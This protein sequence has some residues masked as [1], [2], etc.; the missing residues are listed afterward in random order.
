MGEKLLALRVKLTET[1]YMGT[2]CRW[3]RFF[4]FFFFLFFRLAIFF[5]SNDKIFL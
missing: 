3:R 5:L 1:D 2:R 4:F